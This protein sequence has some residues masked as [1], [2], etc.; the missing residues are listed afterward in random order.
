M[1]QKNPDTEALP[2]SGHTESLALAEKYEPEEFTIL[3]VTGPN[4]FTGAK[5]RKQELWNAGIDLTAWRKELEDG[6]NRL[7][8]WI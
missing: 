3:A 7:V 4:S 5:G 6:Q 2:F 8:Y 1:F